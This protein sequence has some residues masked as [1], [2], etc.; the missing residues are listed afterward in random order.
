MLFRIVVHPEV[1]EMLI[2][3][4]Q[5][6]HRESE[7]RWRRISRQIIDNVLP[8]AQVEWAGTGRNGMKLV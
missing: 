6:A 4:V 8:R 5:Q 1:L 7:E 2:V 3:V